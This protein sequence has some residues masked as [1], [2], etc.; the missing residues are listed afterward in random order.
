MPVDMPLVSVDTV[1][2]LQAAFGEHPGKILYPVFRGKRGHPPLLPMDLAPVIA[3]WNHE[4][5]LRDVLASHEKLAV[6]ISVLDENILLDIDTEEDYRLAVERFKG[7][8]C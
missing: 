4:G 2:S 6:E 5:N 1:R 7:Q 3:G 8:V